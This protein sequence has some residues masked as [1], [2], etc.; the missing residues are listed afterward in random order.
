MLAAAC[1]GDGDTAPS[2]ELEPI[3]PVSQALA[4][5]L[6]AMLAHKDAMLAHKD[7]LLADKDARLASMRKH[8]D[9]M[10]ASKDARLA[11]KDAL[12]ADRDEN[13]SSRIKRKCLELAPFKSQ[14]E[15]GVMLDIIAEERYY[16]NLVWRKGAYDKWGMLLEDVITTE[17]GKAVLT[18]AAMADLNDLD[19][20]EELATVIGDLD[21]KRLSRL[22]SSPHNYG[23]GVEYAGTGW[24][25]GVQPSPSLAVALIITANM[26]KLFRTSR[27][28]YPFPFGG[29][30]R[31]DRVAYL[32][33]RRS[34]SHTLDFGINIR[35]RRVGDEAEE[36][37][38]WRCYDDDDPPGYEFDD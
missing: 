16:M 21:V 24:R 2:P 13:F 27:Y 29:F 36:E 22:V 15:P 1:D 3:A 18:P 14:Y 17:G 7:A 6:D 31:C 23:L 35:W 5:T 12:L 25:L 33:E 38:E 9:A 8:T 26:R 10:L 28:M 37:E 30:H 11:D 32:D 4:T 34:E 20:E 19:S